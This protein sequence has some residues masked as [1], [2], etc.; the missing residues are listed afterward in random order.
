MKGEMKELFDTLPQRGRLEMILLRPGRREPPQSV[1]QAEAIP[2]KGLIGDRFNGRM[3]SKRQVT[4]FQVENLMVLASLLQVDTVDPA[5][6]RRNLLVGGIN[7]NALMNRT[8]RLGE[9][10][11]EGT[12]PCHPCSRMEEALG[13]GGF[14]AM[15]GLGGLCARVVKGGKVVTG[16]PVFPLSA[17]EIQKETGH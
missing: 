14:N 7:L 10:V 15:R 8:F 13:P 16:D 1:E 12:V 2:G 3:E 6:L 11:L 17:S 4:L 9:L 5:M